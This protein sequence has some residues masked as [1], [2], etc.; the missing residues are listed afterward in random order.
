MTVVL[1][2]PPAPADAQPS[3]RRHAGGLPILQP[4][5]AGIDIGATQVYV[6]VPADR[7]P[8]PVR[9]FRTFTADLHALAAWLQQCG[10]RAVAMEATGVYWIPTY[11]I[12]AAAGFTVCLVNPRHFKHVSGRKT[13]V[14]DCQWLQHLFSVGIL[15]P[16]FR[17]A[18]EICA[19]RT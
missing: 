13:D 16:S 1:P 10:I 14:S 18:D 17:P 6:A 19:L 15:Q 5:T 8:E 7:D 9:C 3:R 4:D 12:L 11:Q 2:N